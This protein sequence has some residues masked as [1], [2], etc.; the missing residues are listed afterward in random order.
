MCEAIH[1]EM[2]KRLTER[3]G[4]PQSGVQGLAAAIEVYFTVC[5]EMSD[6]ILLIYQETK[7]LPAESMGFV[8]E[9][10]ERIARIFRDLIDQGCAD[11]TLKTMGPDERKLMATNIVVLGHMWTFRRWSLAKKLQPG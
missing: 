3:I 9:Y 5:H 11:S 10:D 2:E 7:S 6:H 4:Q 1:Q 8:L